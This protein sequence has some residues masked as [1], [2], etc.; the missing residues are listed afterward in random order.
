MTSRG[1]IRIILRIWNIQETIVH[2]DSTIAYILLCSILEILLEGNRRH[3][4]SVLSDLY[5]D[6]DVMDQ[7]FVLTEPRDPEMVEDDIEKFVDRV[8]YNFEYPFNIQTMINVESVILREVVVVGRH[9]VMVV[10]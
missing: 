3:A 4:H 6:V 2:V 10:L 7:V 9:E 8:F 1:R 5:S